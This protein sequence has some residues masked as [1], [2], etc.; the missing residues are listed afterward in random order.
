MALNAIS[1]LVNSLI[2]QYVYN[3]Y[4]DFKVVLCCMHCDIC[5]IFF[6]RLSK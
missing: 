1:F 4:N 2:E 3:V 6:I 5:Y